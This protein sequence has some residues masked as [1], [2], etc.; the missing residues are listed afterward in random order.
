MVASCRS[1]AGC[2][3]GKRMAPDV[4]KVDRGASGKHRPLACLKTRVKPLRFNAQRVLLWFFAVVKFEGWI[5]LGQ[6]TAKSLEI[7]GG[8]D[9]AAIG[10][11]AV[12][13]A[14]W[15]YQ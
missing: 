7:F 2:H 4:S 3:F 13:G 14:G 10:P 6:C 9:R 5:G 1:D 11:G 12:G 15:R 8:P